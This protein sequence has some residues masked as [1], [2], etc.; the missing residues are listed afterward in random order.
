MIVS[1][2]HLTLGKAARKAPYS[3][4]KKNGAAPYQALNFYNIYNL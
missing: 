3:W 2:M 4:P 1:D